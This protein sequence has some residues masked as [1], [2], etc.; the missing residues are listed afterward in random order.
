[1]SAAA[2]VGVGTVSAKNNRCPDGTSLLAKYNVSEGEFV[3]EKG[4]DVVTFTSV[5]RDSEG[6]ITGFSWET[7]DGSDSDSAAETVT[8][9]SVKYGPNTEEIEPS[10]DPED[11]RSGSVDLSDEKN[12]ISNVEFC[13]GA[14][15]QVDFFKG[16]LIEDLCDDRYGSRALEFFDWGSYEGVLPGQGQDAGPFTIE[17]GQ[18]SIDY[19]PDDY[20]QQVGLAVYRVPDPDFESDTGNISFQNTRCRQVLFDY[21]LDPEG[22]QDGNLSADLPAP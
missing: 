14:Y 12:A 4:E 3:F 20:D 7:S 5:Q 8:V 13:Q 16:D 17:D 9:Y 1:M 10:F 15:A 21:E 19:N 6:E 11:K 18:V 2:S 22:N